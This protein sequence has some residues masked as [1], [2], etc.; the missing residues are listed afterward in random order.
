MQFILSNLIEETVWQGLTQAER[1]Q[2]M[3]AFGEY[4][5]AL[6]AADAFVAAYRP[7]PSFAAKT[8]RVSDGETQV[9][10]GPYAATQEQLS[11]LYI[12]DAADLDEALSWAARSPVMEYGTVEVRPVMGLRQ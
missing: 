1:E 6:R 7:E 9:Q 5:Q 2:K 12:L 4:A 3:A 10:D 8:V 11:G